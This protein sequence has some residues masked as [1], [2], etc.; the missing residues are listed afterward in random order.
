MTLGT[1]VTT[2][3]CTIILLLYLYDNRPENEGKFINKEISCFSCVIGGCLIKRTVKRPQ[4]TVNFN[5]EG[6]LVKWPLGIPVARSL[7]R[8][9][10]FVVPLSGCR[11]F[12]CLLFEIPRYWDINIDLSCVINYLTSNS[13][14]PST[15]R[16]VRYT[17]TAKVWASWW[18]ASISLDMEAG[19]SWGERPHPELEY[20]TQARK[21]IKQMD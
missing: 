13:W 16:A 7:H 5:Y 10:D 4:K 18:K 6:I 14:L 19:L 21:G 9:P 20:S 2:Q 11:V 12:Q 3:S 17:G 8:V 1:N 15:A